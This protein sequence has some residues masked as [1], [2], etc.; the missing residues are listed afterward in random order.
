MKNPPPFIP[1]IICGGSG[2]RLWPL[3]RRSLP[4]PFVP[5]PGREDG[6]S[7]LDM[8]YTRLAAL[9]QHSAAM[10]VCAAEHS[11]LC[12]QAYQHS[13]PHIII[14]EPCARNT[15]PAIAVAAARAQKEFGDGIVVLALPAD[16]LIQNTKAFANAAARAIDAAQKENIVLFGAR[17]SYPATGYGYIEKGEQQSDGVFAANRFVEKPARDKAEQMIKQGNFLWNAGMFCFRADTLQ[18]ELQT[19]APDIA[20]LA[21]TIAKEQTPPA[22][23]YEQFPDI[24][25]DYAVMEKTKNAAVA[26]AAD[27]GWSDAGA[28]QSVGATLPADNNNNRTSGE[29]LLRDSKN[30]VVIG[31][32]KR[33]IA[34]AGVDN[35]H[36]IDGGDALLISGA[37]DG[38]THARNLFAELL[39]QNS[40][41]AAHA[42]SEKRPWG[43]YTVLHEGANF[44]VK[45]ITILP[46]A[47]LSL[48]SHN[49][50]SEHW[51]TVLGEPTIVI[52]DK[53]FQ[54]PVDASCHIPLKAK[55][56]IINE[57]AKPAAII[58][59]QIGSYLGEDDITRHEDD[60]GRA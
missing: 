8:T 50:R 31:G 11:F 20:T 5:L 43:G 28:W 16:H 32:G 6:K 56:R 60:Y 17:A 59:V 27:I 42:P 52:N 47:R 26:E 33:L 3:S 29:V 25:F 46:G 54:M 58:E 21:Q 30:C 12:A 19:H 48:Q 22:S 7:L 13:A 9:P 35:L 51:T 10:T 55:H 49:H 38:E 57:T 53:T 37:K 41:Y 44:K 14:G 36:I 4:K 34:A 1:V 40:H 24:S 15:A 18:K 2:S 45:I 23:I 39:K